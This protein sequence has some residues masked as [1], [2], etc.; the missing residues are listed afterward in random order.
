MCED[1]RRFTTIPDA[2]D[3]ILQNQIYPQASESRIEDVRT[4]F[5]LG[6]CAMLEILADVPGFLVDSLIEDLED[7]SEALNESIWGADPECDHQP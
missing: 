1:D 5:A 7:Q 3:Y 6:C 4:G 2:W